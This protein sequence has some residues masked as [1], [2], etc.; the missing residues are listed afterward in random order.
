MWTTKHRNYGIIGYKR[1]VFPPSYV[2]AHFLFPSAQQG[3]KYEFCLK[4]FHIL[5]LYGEKTINKLGKYKKISPL[6]ML[7]QTSSS[8]VLLR[9]IFSPLCIFSYFD[10]SQGKNMEKFGKKDLFSP[11]PLTLFSLSSRVL[12]YS[13][14][15]NM[16][17]I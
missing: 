17:K 14:R 4:S 10:I 11:L 9:E 2:V 12:T 3:G 8:R 15:Y 13:L 6:A 16:G 7:L 5:I 1:I